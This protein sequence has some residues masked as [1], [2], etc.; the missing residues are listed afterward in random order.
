[1]DGSLECIPGSSA[2][3]QFF[4]C[5]F[6]IRSILVHLKGDSLQNIYCQLDKRRYLIGAKWPYERQIRD[7]AARDVS[8]KLKR[9]NLITRLNL[10]AASH[11][12][13]RAPVRIIQ[14]WLPLFVDSRSWP[15][16]PGFLFLRHEYFVEAE[17]PHQQHEEERDRNQSCLPPRIQ[18]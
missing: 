17:D 5:I 10:S 3:Q 14:N 16:S 7:F 11:W 15:L 6:S 13:R 8:P 1:M 9:T 4:Q 18:N 2:G 12:L